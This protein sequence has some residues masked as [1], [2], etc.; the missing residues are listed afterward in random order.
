MRKPSATTTSSTSQGVG[1]T[2]VNGVV[3]AVYPTGRGLEDFFIQKN[4]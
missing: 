1:H 2:V 4:G 3:R